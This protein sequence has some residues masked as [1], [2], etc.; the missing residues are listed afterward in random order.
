MYTE[1]YVFDPLLL[2][3]L[4]TLTLFWIRIR[5]VHC[6]S[7]GIFSERTVHEIA[8]KSVVPSVHKCLPFVVVGHVP[9]PVEIS[10]C[11]T[12]SDDMCAVPV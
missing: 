2:L 4:N 11:I 12:C 3:S 8:V 9:T 10:N 6:I 7:L 1:A 5:Y